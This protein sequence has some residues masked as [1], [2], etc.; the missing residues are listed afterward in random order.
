MLKDATVKGDPSSFVVGA[1]Q[2]R[3]A[4]PLDA[5]TVTV[6][7]RLALPPGPVQVKVKVLVC[8]SGPTSSLPEVDFSPDQALPAWHDVAL[9]DD[10]LRLE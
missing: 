8:V 9:T 4:V 7:G 1:I 6:T 5:V 3:S 2:D 10:Q